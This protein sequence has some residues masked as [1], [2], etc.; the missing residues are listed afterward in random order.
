MHE[1][2][3]ACNQNG[4]TANTPWNATPSS[5]K[6]AKAQRKVLAWFFLQGGLYIYWSTVIGG[7]DQ[8]EILQDG[9]HILEFFHIF[10]FSY[11]STGSRTIAIILTPGTSIFR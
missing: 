7:M 2:S 4:G 5:V 9:T 1:R 11:L 6:S 10:I 8:Y 3:S